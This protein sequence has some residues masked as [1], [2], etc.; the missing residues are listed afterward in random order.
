MS[1]LT[2]NERDGLNELFYRMKMENL[3]IHK[4]MA[5]KTAVWLIALRIKLFQRRGQPQA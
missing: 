5:R 1:N 3:P 2:K 4:K